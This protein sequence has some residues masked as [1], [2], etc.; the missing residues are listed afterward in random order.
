MIR[1]LDQV[2]LTNDIP[3]HGLKAGEM[4]TV[5]LLHGSEGYEV[6]FVAL[7]RETV[8]VVSLF[9]RDVRP[10]GHREIAHAQAIGT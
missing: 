1:E 9:T 7:D 8:A 2:A 10:V 4:D 5:V 6:E 3:E